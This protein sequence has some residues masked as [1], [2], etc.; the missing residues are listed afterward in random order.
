[1][2]TRFGFSISGNTCDLVSQ[3]IYYFGI[4]EPNLTDYMCR[5]LKPG[6]VFVDVGANIG[7]FTLLASG[8]VHSH[9]RVVA[10]E[11][12]PKIFTQLSSNLRRNRA[13]NVRAVNLAAADRAAVLR[14]YHGPA[15][16]LGRTTTVGPQGGSF[17]C[18]VESLPLADILS[19]QETEGARLIKIDVEGAEGSVVRGLAPLLVTCRPDLEVVVEISPSRLAIA[20]TSTLDI[21]EIFGRSG[22][23]AYKLENDYA[24][25]AYLAGGTPSRPTRLSG[26]V[27][28]QMDVIFSRRD[29]A[30]L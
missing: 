24:A 8:L 17:D 14:L 9:G 25:S 4:W 21:F 2:M 5:S 18:V 30:T 3:Y 27:D 28:R 1:M 12:S 22:F 7:Y 10:I 19:C 26:P 6:D 11:A 13:D 20:G 15:T 16:N 29:M 23:H